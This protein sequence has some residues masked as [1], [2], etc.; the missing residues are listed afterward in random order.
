MSNGYGSRRCR[1]S[2]LL[3]GMS[4]GLAHPAVTDSLMPYAVSGAR[5]GR[6]ASQPVH[7]SAMVWLMTQHAALTVA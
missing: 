7:V 3:G 6:A 1:S 5:V 2:P 4:C